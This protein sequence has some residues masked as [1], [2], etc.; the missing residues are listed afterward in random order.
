MLQLVRIFMLT[1]ANFQQTLVKSLTVGKIEYP[2]ELLSIYFNISGKL[3]ENPP[4][5][6][7]LNGWLWST[8]LPRKAFR[9][10]LL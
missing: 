4:V 8:K 1:D 2:R 5:W 9:I 10:M 6:S 3:L 7:S